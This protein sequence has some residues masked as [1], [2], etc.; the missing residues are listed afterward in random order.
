MLQFDVDTQPFQS[1]QMEINRPSANGAAAGQ[2]HAGL[3]GPGH[4]RRLDAEHGPGVRRVGE[5]GQRRRHP[6]TQAQPHRGPGPEAEATDEQ[7]DLPV[8]LGRGLAQAP[9][10]YLTEPVA[11]SDESGKGDYFG[12]LVVSAVVVDPT[13]EA[14]LAT[15]GVRDSKQLSDTATHRAAA[16][17]SAG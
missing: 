1:T 5:H 11:G 16:C 2:G 3:A 7:P 10:P 6:R 4:G 12:P 13:Q 8:E 9:S 17:C 15:A 14:A